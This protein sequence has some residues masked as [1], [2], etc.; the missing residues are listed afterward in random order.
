MTAVETVER[1]NMVKR[2]AIKPGDTVRV[3]V[4]VREG[5]KERI[6]VFEGM[7]I[8]MHRGGA[9]ATFTVRKVSFGQGVERIFPLHSPII[10]KID[11]VRTARVRRA[12]LYFLRE[13]KGK[14]ARMKDAAEE[15]DGLIARPPCPWS[16]SALSGRS[17]TRSGGWGS[18]WSPAWTRSAAAASRAPSS[19]RPSSSIRTATSPASA[20]PRPSPRSSGRVLYEKITRN[21]IAW[22]VAAADPTEIDTI[23]IHQ[24]SLRAMQRA[25][26]KLVPLPDFVLVD[27]FRVPDLLMAQRAV[28]HGDARCTAI[29]AASIVAKVTRDRMML[30]LHA[31]RSPLRIRSPQGLR[32]A[33]SSGRGFAVRLFA[34]APPLV[35]AALAV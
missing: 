7:V 9:R 1:G 33:R 20:I 30:E 24:A 31:Q 16:R 27:A 6:Q 5:D 13:L 23:N 32:H 12:K 26:L 17:R 10:D 28:I 15:A 2:P 8:G 18:T 4:K 22:G 35:P 14:A 21:S 3:H 19:P 25:I 11:V 29:A 34:G